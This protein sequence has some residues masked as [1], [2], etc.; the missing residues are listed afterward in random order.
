MPEKGDLKVESVEENTDAKIF[1]KL[2]LSA[3]DYNHAYEFIYGQKVYPQTTQKKTIRKGTM[4]VDGEGQG[5]GDLKQLVQPQNLQVNTGL[6]LARKI[7]GYVTSGGYSMNRGYGLGKGTVHLEE[8]TVGTYVLVRNPSST[9]YFKAKIE[10]I[11]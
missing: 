8:V 7:I 4:Q 11:Y 9:S 10:K 1:D 6:D 3:K 5:R 2:Q